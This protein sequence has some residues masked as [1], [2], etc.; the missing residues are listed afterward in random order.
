MLPRPL[1]PPAHRHREH[2]YSPATSCHSPPQEG[3][4][5]CILWVKTGTAALLLITEPWEAGIIWVGTMNKPSVATETPSLAKS[6]SQP[7]DASARSSTGPDPSPC[8]G[9]AANTH[10]LLDQ[11]RWISTGRAWQP[12]LPACC[13]ILQC[14]IRAQHSLQPPHP[15]PGI[16]PGGPSTSDLCQIWLEPATEC[17]QRPGSPAGSWGG[18]QGAGTP[19]DPSA[20]VTPL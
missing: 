14:L 1:A 7:R 17:N 8:L 18:W 20:G 9:G 12:W 11:P 10:H 5:L 19:R 15:L 16:L 13:W 3:P 6:L 2:F 4:S